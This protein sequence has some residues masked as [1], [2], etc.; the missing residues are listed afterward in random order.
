MSAS[1]TYDSRSG[2]FLR[3][4]RSVALSAETK[5]AL[6]AQ[7]W[8][9]AVP[10]SPEF[11][12]RGTIDLRAYQGA[13]F[14]ERLSF[15]GKSVLNV[16]CR[17]GYFMF[18]AE[19]AG[20]S[21]VV[22]IDDMPN[23]LSYRSAFENAHALL[24]S[25]SSR[26]EIAL[27]ELSPEKL[28]TFDIVIV[29]EALTFYS[30]PSVVLKKISRLAGEAMIIT[31]HF[32]NDSE[33]IPKLATYNNF[34]R[35]EMY[36]ECC[37]PNLYYFLSAVEA[38]GFAPISAAQ[39]EDLNK[40]ALLAVRD[41]SKNL[42]RPLNYAE[43]PINPAHRGNTAVVVMSCRRF[44]QVWD[45]FFKLFQKY[46]P[47]CPYKVYLGT[48]T[49]AYPGVNNI[50]VGEDRGWGSNCLHILKQIPEE[51]IIFFQEDF[52][53]QGRVDNERVEKF[54]THAHD[55]NIGCLRMVACP[56]PSADWQAC[57]V[58]GTIGAT[59]PYRLSM[60]LAIWDKSVF[61]SLV[62]EGQNPWE[63]E[64]RNQQLA[65]LNPKPFLCVNAD[66][67]QPVP[68]YITA[69]VKGEWQDGALDL[70]RKEG[71]PTEHIKK[72]LRDHALDF[73]A[74]PA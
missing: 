17:D 33:R 47:E 4:G 72:K 3:D 28:G 10:I 35:S 49:G 31:S 55:F 12:T 27:N 71:I 62:K 60:Q 24:G 58:L 66:T 53:I 34:S 9:H 41:P 43:L 69:V 74:K 63:I 56:G 14:P 59:D 45:P 20:A 19:A 70:L 42:P 38:C 23:H 37:A 67:P 36:R 13:I 68:Y 2:V 52:L 8:Y 1:L 32:L 48:D 11:V 64:V 7:R 18:Q 5:D 61:Q 39:I 54:V 6:S 40:L 44:E 21:R 25:K 51:R 50:V 57:D 16:G 15:V 65:A 30:D 22:G 46:W 73:S 26:V 29:S